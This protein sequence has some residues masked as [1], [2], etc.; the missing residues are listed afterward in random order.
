MSFDI[1]KIGGGE[2]FPFMD[3][4]INETGG[5]E[6]LPVDPESTERVCFRQLSPDRFREL[7]NKHKGKK[8]NIPVMNTLSKAMEVIVQYEQ[9]P[10]QEKAQS[11]E[12]WDEAITDWEIDTPAGVPI[13]CTS[14]NKY[15]LVMGDARFLRYANKCLK[16]LSGN[17]EEA[18]KN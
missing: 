2:W 14:E 9:T 5:V 12:F 1:E 18:E 8:I 10:A 11:V 3:S 13:P 15:K 17:V 6:W 16:L 4:R 7:Q